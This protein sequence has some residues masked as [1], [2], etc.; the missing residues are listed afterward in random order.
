MKNKPEKIRSGQL[1]FSQTWNF[2]NVYLVKQAGRSQATAESYR[3]SLTIFKNYLVGELG[4]S[5]STFQFS[6]CTKECIYNFRE[7]LLAN[8]SQP[9]TVNVRVAA[10]RAYLNYASDMDISIQSVALAVS[11]ISP[12]KTIKKEKP[13]LSEDALAAILS[14]PPDTKFGVRDRA[15]LILLYDTAVRVSELLNIRLCDVAMESKYPNIFITGK[16]NKERTIQLTAKAAGHLKEYMRVYHS[17]SS[18]E[19]YLFSTTIKG[20]A[21]RMSVGNVQRIIKKYAALVSEAGISIP[22]PVYCHMF[23]RTR[24]TNLYQDGIAIEL[25]ST[26]LGHARTD[27]T[28]NYR[29]E[30]HTSELQSQR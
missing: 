21:D 5:I 22:D 8:G 26:V 17:N 18:K 2:L 4:K 6:D 10:I 29:S 13:V 24:A 3:D 25:V 15:I 9:S 1:F 23:R 30:E 12:C 16:G 7:Y 20:V 27:T 19:A 11:Q 28:K 14:A